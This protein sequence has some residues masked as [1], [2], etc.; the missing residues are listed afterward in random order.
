MKRPLD[1][2]DWAFKVDYNDHFET[3]RRAYED[4]LPV[5]ESL[6]CAL[7]KQRDELVI[8]DP[9]YCKGKMVSLLHSLGYTTV[10]NKNIDFYRDVASKSVP[11]YDILVTNPPY[12]GEHK[13]QLMAYL[14]TTDKP[15]AL[16]LPV[17]TVTKSY[18]KDL[19]VGCSSEDNIL[20]LL[21]PESY[22]Y[23]HP[24]GT[25]KD[26]PPFYSSWF[27]NLNKN[28]SSG[29]SSSGSAPINMDVVV[30]AL[31]AANP[32]GLLRRCGYALSIEEIVRRGL[33][34]EKRPSNKQRKKLKAKLLLASGA[35]AQTSPDRA[36]S[37]GGS[38]ITKKKRF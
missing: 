14:T 2:S 8:Y 24:E 32:K 34:V 16:L 25:G 19:V 6:A 31:N 15:Y 7:G 3:P 4:L 20:Y 28:S 11:E 1:T 10:I 27:I 5:L 21:P 26:V 36:A 38:D 9:Y 22:D 33:V 17:Y 35:S 37:V 18:W 13:P 23:E 12:S 30:G 29:S